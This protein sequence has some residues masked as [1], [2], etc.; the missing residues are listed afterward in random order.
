MLE[1]RQPATP[2]TL[3]VVWRVTEVCDLNC[4]FC[5]YSRDVR[6]ARAV[7]AADPVLA[8]GQRLGEY[9]R[10]R[11]RPVLVSWLGGEPLRWMP[12]PAVARTF[13][14]DWGLHLSA[15]TNGTPLASIAVQALVV[16]T[17]DEL[18]FSL[19]G[20]RE[21]HDHLRGA[22]GLFD[23]LEAGLTQLQALK[24]RQSSRLRLGINMVLTRD[25]IHHLEAVG[26]M[27]A[28]WGAQRLTFNA[29]GGRDR[30][31][32]FADHRLFPEQVAW[33]RQALPGL[34][35]RLASLGVRVM[36]S[37]RYV[38]RLAWAAEAQP[39]PVC[40]MDCQPGKRFLF[41]DEGGLISP[42]S[43]TTREYGRP[44]G[45][46][47]MPEDLDRLPMEWGHARH[48]QAAEAC[49]D[50]PSTQVFGKFDV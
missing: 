24:A 14:H 50:C 9:A 22:P 4:P 38:E 30:P 13:R 45:D 7:A 12:L 5:G 20:P 1:N 31:E 21:V 44:L 37:D 16:E 15:T 6:R 36:G 2:E 18:V 19:D 27:A 42:C 35:T 26:R 39:L 46:L 23:E 32:Y 34:R 40:T 33:L 41:V 43:F 25:N 8:F 47:N 3:V 28:R 29:L 10:R 17:F 48:P 11:G 49:R